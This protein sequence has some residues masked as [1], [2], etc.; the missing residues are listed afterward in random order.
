MAATAYLQPAVTGK[1]TPYRTEDTGRYHVK[2]CVMYKEK[3]L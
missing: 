2:K 3:P 1:Q